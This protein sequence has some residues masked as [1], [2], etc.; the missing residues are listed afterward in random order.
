MVTGVLWWVSVVLMSHLGWSAAA[1]D[2]GA[3]GRRMSNRRGRDGC[4]TSSKP[5]LIRLSIVPA[6]A[7]ASSAAGGFFGVRHR[8][9]L[10][11]PLS[12]RLG[13]VF[14]GGEVLV[15]FEEV[16]GG[17]HQSRRGPRESMNRAIVAWPGRWPAAMTRQ[18]T[19][20]TAFGARGDRLA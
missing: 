19:S 3:P 10:E 17:G 16:V 2:G 7:R 12:R 14:G 15:E 20:S 6:V 11:R 8:A 9:D 18:A 4:S 13:S 5:L 1:D